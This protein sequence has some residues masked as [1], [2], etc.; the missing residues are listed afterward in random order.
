MTLPHTTLETL[1]QAAATRLDGLLAGLTQKQDPAATVEI[2][3][4]AWQAVPPSCAACEELAGELFPEG[5]GPKPPL[6]PH[7]DC[8]REY[9]FSDRV[10]KDDSGWEFPE[11]AEESVADQPLSDQQTNAIGR[12]GRLPGLNDTLLRRMGNLAQ[13]GQPPDV[14]RPLEPLVGQYAHY[15]VLMAYALR[16]EDVTGQPQDL[17]P[18]P[19]GFHD[20]LRSGGPGLAQGVPQDTDRLIASLVELFRANPD[21]TPVFVFMVL[22]H[23]LMTTPS[24]SPGH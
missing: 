8:F 22:R 3:F 2:R 16:Q 23:H 18:R 19:Q 13:P 1:L 10:P 7:C 4:E 20:L 24:R 6:H 9:Q 17:P 15:V 21:V 14:P 5:G 11:G 12:I